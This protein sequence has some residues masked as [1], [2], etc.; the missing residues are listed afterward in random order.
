MWFCCVHIT[1]YFSSC[2]EKSEIF[3]MDNIY[4]RIKKLCD[5]KNISIATME[6]DLKFSKSSISRWPD[7]SPSIEKVI[8]VAD[9]LGVSIDYLLG[10]NDK[11]PALTSDEKQ[12]LKLFQNMSIE[13]QARLMEQA[14]LLSAKYIKIIYLKN[15]KKPC[16][17]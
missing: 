17:R 15:Y 9:Y 10:R 14:D 4:L 7:H 16:K 8:A 2:Q 11:A 5:A 3:R 1:A 13:G 12:L 6:Q